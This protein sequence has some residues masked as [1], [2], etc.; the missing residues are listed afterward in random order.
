MGAPIGLFLSWLTINFF[1][2]SGIDLSGAAYEDQGFGSVVYPYL[3]SSSYMGVTI[4]VL[5]MSLLAAIY[6]ALKALSLK[7]VEAIRKI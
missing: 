2:K 6:P 7:P 5:V 4:M 1:G 3:K